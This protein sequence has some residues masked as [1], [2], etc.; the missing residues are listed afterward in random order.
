VAV[1]VGLGDEK[2]EAEG[3]PEGH[4]FAEVAGEEAESLCLGLLVELAHD[5][6]DEEGDGELVADEE[7]GAEN[8]EEIE[9]VHAFR[10]P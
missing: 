3:V 4:G 1:E 9:E 10:T 5:G 8:G 6:I 2:D 7:A